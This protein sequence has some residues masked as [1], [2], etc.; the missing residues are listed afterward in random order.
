MRLPSLWSMVLETR[1]YSSLLFSLVG[2]HFYL[3]RPSMA[4]SSGLL[5][6]VRVTFKVSLPQRD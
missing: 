5:P 1:T 3:A 4:P 6:L 2:T